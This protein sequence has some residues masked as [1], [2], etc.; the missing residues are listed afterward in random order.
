MYNVGDHVRVKLDSVQKTMRERNKNENAGLKKIAYT[1]VT[2]T[3]QIF[4]IRTVIQHPNLPINNSVM[5]RQYTLTNTAGVVIRPNNNPA[6]QP[7]RFF[8]SDLIRVPANSTPAN[9][10]N[11]NRS[12]YLN[13]FPPLL[14]GQIHWG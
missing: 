1:A 9:V 8:A 5:R 12:L 13:R 10:P 2:Y 6:L 7:K 4:I 3:P 11:F 14:P